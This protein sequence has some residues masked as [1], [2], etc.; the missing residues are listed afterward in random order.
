[1]TKKK[2]DKKKKRPEYVYELNIVEKY[3]KNG[4]IKDAATINLDQFLNDTKKT[5][6]LFLGIF[7]DCTSWIDWYFRPNKVKKEIVEY[8]EKTNN[9]MKAYLMIKLALDSKKK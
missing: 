2:S 8:A 7:L 1:M 4:R 5:T 9:H 6:R 3:A